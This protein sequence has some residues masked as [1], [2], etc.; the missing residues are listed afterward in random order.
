MRTRLIGSLA[1]AG[2]LALA[3]CGGDDD[4]DGG[5][6]QAFCDKAQEVETAGQSLSALQ[7]GDLGAAQEALDET[8]TQV[9]EA[10]DLAPEEIKGDVETVS[11]FISDLT[12]KVQD[13]EN[14][15]DLL[16]V[17]GELQEGAEEVQTAGQN[18]SDY[19]EE[20]CDT[21]TG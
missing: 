2:A 20:N 9:Q 13:A 10:V 1:V 4:D 7:G 17:L 18:V 8:N 19:V 3:G 15:Q 16:G 14:P 11:N 6:L 5:D 21:A 12:E